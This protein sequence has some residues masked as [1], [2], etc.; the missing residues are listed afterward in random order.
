MSKDR[1]CI[2]YGFLLNFT[3]KCRVAGW[4]WTGYNNRRVQDRAGVSSSWPGGLIPIQ[5][6]RGARTKET[7]Q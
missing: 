6:V 1:G 7:R 2:Q 4:Q 3:C 5:L